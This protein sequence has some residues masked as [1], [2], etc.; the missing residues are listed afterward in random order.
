MAMNSK[1]IDFLLEN[2]IPYVYKKIFDDMDVNDLLSV[3]QV[4]QGIKSEIVQKRVLEYLADF[5]LLRLNCREWIELFFKLELG[6]YHNDVYRDVLQ[7]MEARVERLFPSLTKYEL[8]RFRNKLF[9]YN[10]LRE[11]VD[12]FVIQRLLDQGNVHTINGPHHRGERKYM[13]QFRQALRDHCHHLVYIMENNRHTEN[14]RTRNEYVLYM[15]WPR[16]IWNLPGSVNRTVTINS[17]NNIVSFRLFKIVRQYPSVTEINLDC[18]MGEDLIVNKWRSS[19]QRNELQ[20]LT[21]RYNAHKIPQGLLN[22]FTANA[23]HPS[24]GMFEPL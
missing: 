10:I 3:N 9:T 6:R 2:Q 11:A 24:V 13:Q 7:L 18:R 1:L 17:D 5:G 4:F 12:A 22:F 16:L 8:A 21:I 20:G 15:T 19:L 14:N 23:N